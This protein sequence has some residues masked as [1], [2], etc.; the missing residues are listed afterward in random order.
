M[1]CYKGDESLGNAKISSKGK[2]DIV[3]KQDIANAINTL[4]CSVGKD[5]ASKIG[6][7]PNPTVTEE[8]NHNKHFN[9][10]AI[11]L[12][13]IRESMVKI[14][15]SK[16][17]E[18]DKVSSYF[19]KLAIPFIDRLLAFSFNTSLKTSLFPG[20][21]KNARITPIFK[22]GDKAEKSNYRQS[23]FSLYFQG[24]LRF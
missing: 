3:N 10:K 21:W 18:S 23:R 17:F 16:S 14:K 4:F 15:T 7:V 6:A 9:F 20:S 24:F 5:L 2:A 11:G 8:Y 19:L 22:E 13:E 1:T 12:Q